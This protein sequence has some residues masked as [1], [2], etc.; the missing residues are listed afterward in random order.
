[1][2]NL[3]DIM[4]EAL[5]SNEVIQKFKNCD[6]YKSIEYKKPYTAA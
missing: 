3:K 5:E 2:T 4:A 1:M 6:C